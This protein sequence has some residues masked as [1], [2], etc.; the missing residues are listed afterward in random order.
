MKNKEQLREGLFKKILGDMIAVEYCELSES[1]VIK[2]AMGA[3]TAF[4]KL[5]FRPQENKQDD[6]PVGLIFRMGYD[7][8]SSKIVAIKSLGVG[9][10]YSFYS[11]FPN[12]EIYEDGEQRMLTLDLLLEGEL[13]MANE[14]EV[15]MLCRFLRKNGIKP[16]MINSDG[17][18]VTL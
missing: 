15:G 14:L 8:T 4:R 12:G 2:T 18:I 13:A 5:Y 16:K 6:L 17:V 3:I 1:E 7:D 11:A 9:D 10:F